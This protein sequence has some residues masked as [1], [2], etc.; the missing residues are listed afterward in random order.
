M[1]KNLRPGGDTID[2]DVDP[3]CPDDA[4]S[5]FERGAVLLEIDET[6]IYLEI[7]GINAQNV[8]GTITLGYDLPL[9]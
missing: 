8:I 3:T 7:F 6:S 2:M 4:P 9:T 1:E 5:G